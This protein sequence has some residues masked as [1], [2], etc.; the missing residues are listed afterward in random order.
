[1]D[2]AISKFYSGVHMN[3]VPHLD[4]PDESEQFIYK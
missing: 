1:M 3:S 2:D 4:E